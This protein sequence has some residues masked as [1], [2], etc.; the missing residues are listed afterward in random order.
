[1]N[2]LDIT[3]KREKA[4]DRI[5]QLVMQLRCMLERDSIL[6]KVNRFFSSPQHPDKISGPLSLISNVSQMLKW[7]KHKVSLSLLSL[8]KIQN[9]WCSA[10]TPHLCGLV[11][12]QR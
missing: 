10:T 2:S 12:Q 11:P 4:E 5:A 6:N 9:T 8:N 7:H 1:M 3:G